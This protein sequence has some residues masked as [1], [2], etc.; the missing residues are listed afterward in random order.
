MG[1]TVDMDKK[2]DLVIV[3]AGPAGLMAAKTAAENNI[4]VALIDKRN[5]ISRWRRADCMM[6]YGLEGGFLGEDIEVKLGKIIFSKNGFEVGYRGGLYPLYNWRVF[7]PGGHR[8]DFSSEK[9]IAAVF[10]KGIL[11]KGLL[12]EV[13]E[14]GVDH[15][16]GIA[17]P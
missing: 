6:F 15:T 14:L 11:L 9:P 13:Q 12:E 7:S 17:W 1:R 5:D 16:A 3:G 8:I 10:D 2:Y 4:S